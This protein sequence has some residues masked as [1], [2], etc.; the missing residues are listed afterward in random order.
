GYLRFI[1]FSDQALL[2]W[3]DPN[4]FQFFNLHSKC[5]KVVRK[6]TSCIWEKRLPQFARAEDYWLD[7][8]VQNIS[9]LTSLLPERAQKS[10]QASV[11]SMMMK[12]I[13][14][15]LLLQEPKTC[16]GL[17]TLD[18]LLYCSLQY[19]IYVLLVSTACAIALFLRI[20]AVNCQKVRHRWVS[21]PNDSITLLETRECCSPF[22]SLLTSCCQVIG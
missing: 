1:S 13:E 19:L 4:C 21:T 22:K 18:E 12:G 15:M 3:M 6:L 20:V 9:S 14:D 11:N 8:E 17:F 10:D 16:G 7:C 2:Y 5:L